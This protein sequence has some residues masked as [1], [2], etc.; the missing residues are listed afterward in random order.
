MQ[1]QRQ[2]NTLV[3]FVFLWKQEQEKHVGKCRL[4][5]P[6]LNFQTKFCSA[7]LFAQCHHTWTQNIAIQ[8]TL[9]SFS[10]TSSAPA[11][12]SCSCLSVFTLA[13]LC[14]VHW[15]VKLDMRLYKHV[16]RMHTRT[17]EIFSAC[18]VMTKM[19]AFTLVSWDYPS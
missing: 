14:S 6:D 7:L 8:Q 2:R 11:C 17:D 19:A 13:T 9:H 12:L 16:V 3:D 1:R 4:G 10:S 18:F 5:L 15:I